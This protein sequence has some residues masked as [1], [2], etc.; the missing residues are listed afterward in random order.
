MS[1]NEAGEW[2]AELIKIKSIRPAHLS[3]E[4]LPQYLK[5]MTRVEAQVVFFF[6]KKENF[7]IG[8]LTG[9]FG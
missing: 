3:L 9:G 5:R 1:V 2:Y 8:A 7:P 4:R 6:K